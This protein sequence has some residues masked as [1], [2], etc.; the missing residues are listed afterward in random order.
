LEFWDGEGAV[1]DWGVVSGV[2]KQIGEDGRR[3][4]YRLRGCIEVT[5]AMRI[6]V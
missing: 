4:V 2:K 6:N 5:L 1:F 3:V